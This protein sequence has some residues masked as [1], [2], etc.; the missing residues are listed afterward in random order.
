MKWHSSSKEDDRHVLLNV[1]NACKLN[2]K[3]PLPSLGKHQV[4]GLKRW[5]V[6]HSSFFSFFFF[7]EVAG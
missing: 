3:H 2:Q 5:Q 6:K 7:E 1:Q 4:Q